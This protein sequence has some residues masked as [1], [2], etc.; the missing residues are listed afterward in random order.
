MKLHSYASGDGSLS[1]TWL[2][3]NNLS[4]GRKVT[5]RDAE[6]HL[7]TKDAEHLKRGVWEP[8]NSNG[9]WILVRKVTRINH[10]MLRVEGDHGG[11]F[12]YSI[13]PTYCHGRHLGYAA[14]KAWFKM[15]DSDKW[16]ELKN[17]SLIAVICYFLS[18][19]VE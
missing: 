18:N 3:D 11:E 8:K 14:L 15:P 1:L 9:N 12:W 13:D 6:R 2:D 7:N 5:R 17:Q 10:H 16:W 19:E 4:T